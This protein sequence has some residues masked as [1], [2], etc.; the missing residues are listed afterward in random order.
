MRYPILSLCGLAVAS[1]LQ[2]QQVLCGDAGANGPAVTEWPIASEVFTTAEQQILP[3]A[4]PADTPPV[5]PAEVAKYGQFGYSAWEVGAGLQHEKRTELA[6]GYNGAPA[7]ARLMSFFA[8]ADIHIA[9]KESPA[10]PIYAGWSAKYG[11]SSSGLLS[12]AYSPVIL[13][14]TQV[15]DAAVQTVN[16]LHGKSP[17][18]FGIS[19]G[20]DI[21]N[22]QFNELRWFIDVL[23]GKVITPSSG[24]H[25]GADTID[26]QKPYKAAGLNKSIPWYQV[27]GNHDQFWIGIA[28]ENAK[29]QAAHVG[30]TVINM[31]LGLSDPNFINETGV[32]MGVVDGSTPYGDVVGAGPEGELP[33]A[34]GGH[35]RR[36]PSRPRDA[37]VLKPELDARVFHDGFE[38]GR[39]RLQPEQPRQ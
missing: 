2:T 32:Y 7:T 5:N 38:P 29:T 10:Q 31:K 15:L 39:P 19:L 16:A 21:N 35:R 37:G 3:R 13:S 12:Q 6:P 17:F 36:E 20:D 26:Y 33:N 28:Y 30:D 9:D 18:S 4:L 11:P 23:D 34:A 14:T 8:I 25:A 27:I 22:N 1:V 24:A